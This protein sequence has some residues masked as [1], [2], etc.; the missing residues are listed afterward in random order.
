LDQDQFNVQ[1]NILFFRFESYCLIAREYSKNLKIQKKTVFF[2]LFCP[3]CLNRFNDAI[4]TTGKPSRMREMSFKT[5][6][7]SKST[8]DAVAPLSADVRQKHAMLERAKQRCCAE[9]ETFLPT[10]NAISDALVA[11]LDV[12]HSEVCPAVC[13]VRS[14]VA[15]ILLPLRKKFKNR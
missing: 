13:L 11:G 4:G 3:V 5:R 6:F 9:L 15:S 10:L 8:N 7:E 12:Q 1:V 2:C 14:S